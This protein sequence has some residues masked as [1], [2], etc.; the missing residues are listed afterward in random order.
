MKWIVLMVEQ[1]FN[2]TLITKSTYAYGHKHCKVLGVKTVF[3]YGRESPK[4]DRSLINFTHLHVI[5]DV[6]GFLSSDKHKEYF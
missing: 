3:K 5:P 4:N 6:Y 2:V 1:I